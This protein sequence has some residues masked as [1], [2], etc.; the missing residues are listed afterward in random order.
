MIDGE[1][2][3]KENEHLQLGFVLGG[4]GQ[5]PEPRV[6]G[7]KGEVRQFASVLIFSMTTILSA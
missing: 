6:R 2:R 7:K 3:Q 5:R 4:E 1:V